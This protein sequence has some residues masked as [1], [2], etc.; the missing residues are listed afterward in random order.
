MTKPTMNARNRI[1]MMHGARELTKAYGAALRGAD[2][3][4]NAACVLPE[5]SEERGKVEALATILERVA[6]T[7]NGTPSPEGNA[8]PLS[9]EIYRADFVT[10]VRDE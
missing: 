3:M 2:A 10:V 5:G 8:Y 7:L 4:R 9:C 1:A 6:Q